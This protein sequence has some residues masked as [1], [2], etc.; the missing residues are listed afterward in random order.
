MGV[1]FKEKIDDNFGHVM[2]VQSLLTPLQQLP[3]HCPRPYLK[4][5]H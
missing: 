5:I 4:L 1:Y 3:C 2:C